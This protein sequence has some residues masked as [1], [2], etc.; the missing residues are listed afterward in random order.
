MPDKIEPEYVSVAT[1]A[2]LL[3]ISGRTVR[4]RVADGTI[5]GFKVGGLL[6]LRRADL[7]LL[8]RRIPAGTS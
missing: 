4:R 1:A 5:P 6:R 8:T 3:G 2:T 7:D